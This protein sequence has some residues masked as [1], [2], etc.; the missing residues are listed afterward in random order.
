MH[1]CGVDLVHVCGVDLVSGVH[2][3]MHAYACMSESA[4]HVHVAEGRWLHGLTLLLTLLCLWGTY[5]V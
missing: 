4:V 5:E 1:V 3:Y 2:A